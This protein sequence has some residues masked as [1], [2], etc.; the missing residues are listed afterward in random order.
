MVRQDLELT[1]FLEQQHDPLD[2]VCG[3]AAATVRK[4]AARR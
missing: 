3:S 1:L 2:G 4:V